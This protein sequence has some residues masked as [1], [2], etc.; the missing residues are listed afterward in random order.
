VE[1]LSPAW[2]AAF[3]PVDGLVVCGVVFDELC[4]VADVGAAAC[5]A[6]GPEFGAGLVVLVDDRLHLE[7]VDGAGAVLVDGVGDVL[8]EL[9]QAGLVVGGDAGFGLLVVAV[10]AHD[11]RR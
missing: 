6:E 3:P 8:G 7:G 10:A 1:L 2:C 9:A 4:G 11:R 5:P